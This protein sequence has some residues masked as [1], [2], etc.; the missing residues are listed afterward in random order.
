M[1][2]TLHPDPKPPGVGSWSASFN[3]PLHRGA[4]HPHRPR[5]LSRTDAPVGFVVFDGAEIPAEL[6]TGLRAPREY[7]I[8]VRYGLAGGSD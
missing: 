8:G 2:G 6:D 7:V 1:T 3:H 5:G 4:H